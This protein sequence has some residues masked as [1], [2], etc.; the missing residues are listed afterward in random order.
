MDVK[1]A[2]SEDVKLI[3][4]AE[5]GDKLQVVLHTVMSF[6]LPYITTVFQDLRK[7]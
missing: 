7:I 1:K 2:Y 6:P 5:D 4:L 3:N